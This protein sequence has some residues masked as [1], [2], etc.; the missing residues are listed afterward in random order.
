LEGPERVLNR[1]VSTEWKKGG[2]WRRRKGGI[3]SG[4]NDRRG[5]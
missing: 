1:P 2:R 4:R 3:W 5:L